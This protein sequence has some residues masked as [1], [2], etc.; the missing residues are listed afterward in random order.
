MSFDNLASLASRLFLAIAS[1]LLIL[2][3]VEFAVNALGYTV[4]RF[5]NPGRLLEFAAIF[6]VFGATVLLLEIRE[7]L[8][9]RESPG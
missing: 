8:K 6:S 4:L 3:G 9:R 7:E 1:V 2:A 5:Y